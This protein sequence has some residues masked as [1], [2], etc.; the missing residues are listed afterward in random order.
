MI[1]LGAVEVCRVAPTNAT[2][3][4]EVCSVV[5]RTCTYRDELQPG[6]WDKFV[7][8]PIKCIVDDLQLLQP[9][10]QGRSPIMDVW[11]RQWL[12]EKYERTRPQEAALFCV[13]FRVELA[14]LCGA[15]QKHGKIAHYIEPR[16]PDGRAPHGDFR[17][18]RINKM[19]RQG[20]VLASQSTAEWTSIVR[21][22]QR[23]GLR[24]KSQDAQKVPLQHKP[25]TPYLAADDL[26]LLHAGPF[27]HGSDRNA[28]VKLF[29][30]WGWQARPGQPKSR[31][32]NGK[33]VIWEVQ[34]VAKP[35]F[36]VYQLAHADILITQVEKKSYKRTSATSDIQG[37]ART[38]AALTLHTAA[39]SD[40][41][42]PW[43][44]NDPWGKYQ[45]PTKVSRTQTPHGLAP[46]QID[47]LATKVQQRI[48]GVKPLLLGGELSDAAMGSEDRLSQLEDRLT[49]MEATMQD[50]Q[51]KQTQVNNDLVHQI[52]M[53]QQ[54]AEK[55]SLA[56]HSH[57]EN[58]M[59]EQLNH[60]ERLLSKRRAE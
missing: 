42:D 60:I 5:L 18:I 40:D 41:A 4:D 24:V 25:Q 45:G 30:T 50:Q 39:K 28:L 56:I 58:K 8:R 26:L 27:P 51:A 1:Q 9:D 10:S 16:D 13:C 38:I 35:Q 36:E 48:Q 12:T 59:Q 14:D 17:V 43:A 52:G 19:D 37:S 23:F 21:A 55:Q 47:L 2:Q 11:D 57:I 31:A 49:Q 46:E 44:E 20:V 32:P 7:A 34:A 54:Q 15:L 22:G 33:G 53:V 3:V 6:V 29:A